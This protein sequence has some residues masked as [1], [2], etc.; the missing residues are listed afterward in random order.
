MYFGCAPLSDQEARVRVAQVMEANATELRTT[1]HAHPLAVSEVV[2][3]DGF[4]SLITSIEFF[5]SRL[6]FTADL[7][8]L[9]STASRTRMLAGCRFSCSL[10]IYRRS[11]SCS[12][13]QRPRLMFL[14]ALLPRRRVGER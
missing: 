6:C 4:G 2:R 7:P 9:R 11:K 5:S 3:I 1:E 10:A 8:K 13:S 12:C 14:R